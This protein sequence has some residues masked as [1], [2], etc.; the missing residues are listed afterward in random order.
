M[1]NM[2][3]LLSLVM[4]L[5]FS[6]WTYFACL[7]ICHS[8]YW[9]VVYKNCQMSNSLII[10]IG[11]KTKEHN[12]KWFGHYHSGSFLMLAQTTQSYSCDEQRRCMCL[13]GRGCDSSE[14]SH[15]W[16]WEWRT[17]NPTKVEKG[18]TSVDGSQR[19]HPV[20]IIST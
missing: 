2:T 20:S 15:S 9:M 3:E 11:K 17:Q 5:K 1:C 13:L 18:N 6:L 7:N 12:L 8:K 14:G 10:F 4:P 19:S 16:S